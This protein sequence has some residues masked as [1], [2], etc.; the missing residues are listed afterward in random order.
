MTEEPNV[1]GA[2]ETAQPSTGRTLTAQEEQILQ[3]VQATS[4]MSQGLRDR[5][6]REVLGL[7][8]TKYF[9]FLNA[10]LDEPAAWAAY[11]AIVKRLRDRRQR[12]R[13]LHW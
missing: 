2:P 12:N 6:I 11:P 8:P 5:Y 4:S 7:A 9:Q 3:C 13:D 10:L 1:S